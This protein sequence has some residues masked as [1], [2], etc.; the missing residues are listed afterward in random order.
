MYDFTVGGSTPGPTS[1]VGDVILA[2]EAPNAD[3][4]PLDGSEHL[5]ADYPT[6]LGA[7]TLLSR[8]EGPVG[9]QYISDHT[10]SLASPAGF[11]KATQFVVSNKSGGMTL[12]FSASTNYKYSTDGGVTWQDSTVSFPKRMV[13][14]KPY[15][16]GSDFILL[17]DEERAFYKFDPSD[18]SCT[19]LFD[20]YDNSIVSTPVNFY[21]WIKPNAFVFVSKEDAAHVGIFT[22]GTYSA[23][24]FYLAPL[25]TFGS[26]V[27][28]VYLNGDVYYATNGAGATILG[29]VFRLSANLMSNFMS[30]S[31][32]L[33]VTNITYKMP[34]TNVKT[35]PATIASTD[36][37]MEIL[38]IT[39]PMKNTS[40][41]GETFENTYS[42][43]T[44]APHLFR[45]YGTSYVIG[46]GSISEFGN[47]LTINFNGIE[48]DP[49]YVDSSVLEAGFDTLAM[50]YCKQSDSILHA[51]TAP[52]S[53]GV[54][55]IAA[56]VFDDSKFRTRY[57]KSPTYGL[58]YF[59]KGR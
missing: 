26:A 50:T 19:L 12:Y 51:Y 41:D 47:P 24:Q 37:S 21:E 31:Y 27:G 34:N 30:N 43:A 46:E 38:Y 13:S 48:G 16:D 11:A 39:N 32:R 1:E 35:A 42:F 9:D 6:A 56:G 20:I 58:S 49:S 52:G 15:V 53:Y 3:W 4:L 8:V 59:I 23:F 29:N 14:G 28:M 2:T 54:S 17:C 55:R 10:I 33:A 45:I 25:T 18:F 5:V 36:K 57:I 22:L 7:S 44:E 40:K